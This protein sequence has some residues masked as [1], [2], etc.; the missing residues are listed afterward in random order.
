MLEGGKTPI[1][2]SQGRPR[3]LS[4]VVY[5]RGQRVGAGVISSLVPKGNYREDAGIRQ[6][7]DS[8]GR[9]RKVWG[10][11]RASVYTIIEDEIRTAIAERSIPESGGMVGIPAELAR[12]SEK[13]LRTLDIRLSFL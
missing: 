12:N 6:I 9:S 4:V 10:L 2:D 3:S 5:F 11:Q 7:A 1:R 13:W 8:I